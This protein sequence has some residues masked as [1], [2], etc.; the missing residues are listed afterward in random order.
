MELGIRELCHLHLRPSLQTAA[1]DYER[2]KTALLDSYPHGSHERER[3]IDSLST[4]ETQFLDP[5]RR[6]AGELFATVHGALNQDTMNPQ[7]FTEPL[8]ELLGMLCPCKCVASISNAE[9]LLRLDM[10]TFVRTAVRRFASQLSDEDG[11]QDEINLLDLFYCLNLGSIVCT[12]PENSNC[13]LGD[14]ADFVRATV[15]LLTYRTIDAA[16]VML[17]WNF[18]ESYDHQVN[19]A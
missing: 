2:A 9:H 16:A 3:A 17:L 5:G 11:R 7:S 4:Q 14:D 10:G 19:L 15:K 8:V 1:S 6:R 12:T 13:V 18:L